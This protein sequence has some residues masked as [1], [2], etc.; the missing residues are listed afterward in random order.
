MARALLLLLLLVGCG[1]S[2]DVESQLTIT[3]GVYGQLTARCDGAGCVG[4]P[5]EGRPMAWFDQSPWP[6]DGGVAPS[7]VTQ[8]TSGKNG[9]YELAVDSNAKGYIALGQSQATTGVQWV[10]ATPPVTVP[11]GLARVDWRGGPDNAGT[12][13]EVR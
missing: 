5:L 12:W 8:T 13:T 1:T 11:K 9:F 6:T 4:A 7:P 3:Q 10:T 2:T